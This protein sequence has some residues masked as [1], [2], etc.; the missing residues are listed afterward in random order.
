MTIITS[1]VGKQVLQVI[2]L[3]G[4]LL[5]SLPVFAGPLVHEV[6]VDSVDYPMPSADRPPIYDN[7]PTAI[8]VTALVRRLMK[9]RKNLPETPA[10]LRYEI[11]TM[12]KGVAIRFH[13]SF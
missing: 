2:G 7:A 11:D 13:M 3:A 12:A 1:R 6:G 8:P 9:A 5:L 10:R 4:L